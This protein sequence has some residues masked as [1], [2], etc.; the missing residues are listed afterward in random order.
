[1]G[2]IGIY[3][4]PKD[5]FAALAGDARAGDTK[6][7]LGQSVS[8]W[9][10][11][12][13]LVLPRTGQL[14]PSRDFVTIVSAPEVALEA[15][16]VKIKLSN[17]ARRG[18]HTNFSVFMRVFN[19]QQGKVIASATRSS[20]I[21]GIVYLP[22]AIDIAIKTNPQ[23]SLIIWP[24]GYL[25]KKID[26]NR[27]DEVL[28]FRPGNFS[29]QPAEKLTFSDVL[30]TLDYYLKGNTSNPALKAAYPHRPGLGSVIWMLFAYLIGLLS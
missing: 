3:G 2:R 29:S 17:A 8:G 24:A 23:S 10:T 15:P 21:S 19:K 27:T 13:Q 4:Q 16:A 28:R 11:G 22:E 7:V 20:D 9:Q 18:G 5:S 1:M 6:L 25:P 30:F 14:R 26:A 12:D